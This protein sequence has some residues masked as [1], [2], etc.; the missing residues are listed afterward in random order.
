MRKSYDSKLL[1]LCFFLHMGY[2]SWNSSTCLPQTMGSR[3][4]RLNRESGNVKL[5]TCVM[6]LVKST[7]WSAKKYPA[8]RLRST[9][10]TQVSLASDFL[11]ALM[12]GQRGTVRAIRTCGLLSRSAKPSF[13]LI[14]CPG[15]HISMYFCRNVACHIQRECRCG[16]KTKTA[17]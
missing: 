3:S 1:N 16:L 2:L 4:S 14:A 17:S 9:M 6:Y 10:D 12:R 5:G 11:T 13:Y 7:S 8:A 15:N